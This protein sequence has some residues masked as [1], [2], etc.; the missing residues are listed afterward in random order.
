PLTPAHDKNIPKSELL[1]P[2]DFSANPVAG[3]P[4]AATLT[5]YGANVQEVIATVTGTGTFANPAVTQFG[6]GNRGLFRI[7]IGSK[8]YAY[9]IQDTDTLNTIRDNINLIP[10]LNAAGVTAS[11]VTSG[12]S[13]QLK[14]TAAN[15][16]VDFSVD[17]ASIDATSARL[18][19]T[20]QAYN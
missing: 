17:T 4:T 5:G 15:P 10:G 3:P 12:G 9:T 2:A 14:L 1:N 18:G 16:D 13:S 7:K 6:A 8:N 19:I 20:E 11:V